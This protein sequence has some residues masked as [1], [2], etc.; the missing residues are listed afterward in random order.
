MAPPPTIMLTAPEMAAAEVEVEAA[1]F[2]PLSTPAPSQLQAAD[3]AEA[4][5][6][7]EAAGFHP[8]RKCYEP[9]ARRS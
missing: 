3:T 6:E 8:R 4:G 9:V 1:G 2:H 7:A 5:M